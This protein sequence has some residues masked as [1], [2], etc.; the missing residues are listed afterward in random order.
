MNQTIQNIIRMTASA[1]IIG[2]TISTSMAQALVPSDIADAGDPARWYQEDLTARAI[3]QTSKKDVDAAYKE[4]VISC[5]QA[6][7][8]DRTTCAQE[9]RAQWALDLDKAKKKQQESRN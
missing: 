9:A 6:D 2:L 1:V 4:A 5:K 3:F 8:R 7:R